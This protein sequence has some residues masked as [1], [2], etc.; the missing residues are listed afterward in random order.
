MKQ[1]KAEMLE[2][3]CFDILKRHGVEPGCAQTV[4]RCLVDADLYGISTHGVSRLAIYLKRLDAGVVEKGNHIRIEKESA[5][6]LVIDA[7]NSLGMPAAEFAMRHCMEKAADAGCCFATVKNSNHFGAA[8]YY[9]RIAAAHGMIGICLANLGPKIAP[10]GAAEPYM[11][12]NPISIAAPGATGPVVLDMAPSVVALG[13]LILAQKLGR[14][15]PQGW[16][17][18]KD[19]NPTTDPAEGRAGSL[20]PIGGPKGSGL[21]ILVDIFCGVLSGGAFGPHL[22]DLYGDLQN[23]QGVGHFIGAID[24]SHFVNVDDFCRGVAQM[25]QEIKAL[26]PAQGFEEIQLPGE[27]G[28]NRKKQN[29]KNGICLPDEIFAELLSLGQSCGAVFPQD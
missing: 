7:G 16:A 5:A 27:G 10:Y 4:A 11:G 14:Q 9:T 28:E 12:T 13:K 21:A 8:A 1:V 17:L 24:I 6:A 2:T 26:R 15:I 20:L 23:P 3:Y 25:K 22:H 19:G 18:D 29:L